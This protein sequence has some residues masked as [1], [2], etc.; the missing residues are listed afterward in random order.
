MQNPHLSDGDLER[1]V[2]GMMH[3]DAEILWV[4]K[5]LFSCPDCVER[6]EAIQDALDDPASGSAQTGDG[7][8]YSGGGPLQ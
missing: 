1:Y 7:D 2:S 4:E 6:M 8:L 5:H 3:T